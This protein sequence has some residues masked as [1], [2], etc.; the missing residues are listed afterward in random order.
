MLF[1]SPAQQARTPAQQELARQELLETLVPQ[2][3]TRGNTFAVYATIGFF[4]V[5]NAGTGVDGLTYPDAS[6]NRPILGAEVLGVDGKPVRYKFFSV[7]DRT[8]LSADTSGFNLQGIG[9][10]YLSYEPNVAI[11]S[12][13][14]QV[15][16]TVQVAVPITSF[17]GTSG[18]PNA[19]ARG[20]YD[21]IQWRIG[22]QGGT[23]GAGYQLMLDANPDSGPGD[24]YIPPASSNAF[25]PATDLAA[26][27][28]NRAELVNI[29]QID[30]EPQYGRC[31]L[32]FTITKPHAR[33]CSMRLM[34]PDSSTF[35]FPA[36]PGNPGPQATTFSSGA[37]TYRT[38]LPVFERIDGY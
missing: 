12:P 31:L 4:E 26:P 15:G 5:L 7:V 10:T 21:G 32:K 20:N 16:S 6:N 35:P 25:L 36:R 17:S 23:A 2:L 22:V 38:V 28:R 19:V 34:Q 37:N 8:Q 11:G 33:G 9:V 18:L 30:Y 14:P 1:R 3:T 27:F 13:D 24:G 29:T